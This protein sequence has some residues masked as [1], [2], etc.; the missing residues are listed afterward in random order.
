VLTVGT[1]RSGVLACVAALFLATAGP[2]VAG[3]AFD[4]ARTAAD[5]GDARAQ[6]SLGFM[7]YF[8]EG[9]PQDYAEA[10]RWYRLAA[11]QGLAGAQYNLRDMYDNGKGVPQD[12]AEAVRWYRLAAEQ[13]DAG[14]QY[15]LGIMY[16]NG[17]G[18]PQD[19]VMAHMWANL[20]AAQGNVLASKNCGITASKMTS[21]QIAEAQRLARE[22]KPKAN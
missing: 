12:D 20:A 1:F 19:Y 16:D 8:G 14:A 6:Y 2:C 22:W 17:Q 21:G 9:I 5:Q 3:D 10:V 13:G 7:Y 15:S 4:A 11:E 18:V